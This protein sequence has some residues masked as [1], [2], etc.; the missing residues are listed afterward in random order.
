MPKRAGECSEDEDGED[1]VEGMMKSV[2]YVCGII[3]VEVASGVPVERVMVGGFSQGCVIALLVGLMS[4]YKGQLGGAV[5]LSGYL[6]LV[7]KVKNMVEARQEEE[8]RTTK[9]FLVHGSRDQLVPRRFFTKYSEKM[10]EWEG[11]RVQAKMYEGLGHTI[12]GAELRDL[13]AWLEGILG[14]G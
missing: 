13:C 3:D 11:E 7:G 4:R 10:T 1:D 2:E 5:G 12:S 14:V 8:K 9:W 6:P